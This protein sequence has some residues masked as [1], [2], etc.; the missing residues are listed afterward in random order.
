MVGSKTSQNVLIAIN[1]Y[2]VGER[3]KDGCVFSRYSCEI[4]GVIFRIMT[5]LLE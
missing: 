3:E 5:V 4:C 1:T 2:V